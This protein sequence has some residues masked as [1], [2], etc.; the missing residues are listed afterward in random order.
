MG[1]TK[2]NMFLCDDMGGNGSYFNVSGS[3]TNYD[4]WKFFGESNGTGS[5]IQFPVSGF[6]HHSEGQ[7]NETAFGRNG[8]YWSALPYSD[9]FGYFLFIS[10][11]GVYP[12]F[13]Y[14][15]SNAFSVRP[16]ADGQ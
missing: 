16:I 8:Y 4:G 13:S 5:E 2:S 6:R 15:K 1:R 9:K 3:F 11:T 14:Q 7:L 10:K 12:M